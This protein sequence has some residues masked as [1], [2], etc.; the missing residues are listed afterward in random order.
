MRH[1]ILSLI[2][3]FQVVYTVLYSQEIPYNLT[4]AAECITNEDID[5]AKEYLNKELQNNPHSVK[6]LDLLGYIYFRDRNYGKAISLFDKAIEYARKENGYLRIK[7][8]ES[9]ND[10][11]SIRMSSEY[12]LLLEQFKNEKKSDKEVTL[13][14]LNSTEVLE[15]P[16]ILRRT[17]IYTV[18]CFLNEMPVSLVLDTGCTNVSISLIESD[19]MLKNGYISQND[20]LGYENYQDATGNYHKARILLIKKF[21]IGNKVIENVRASVIPN[22]EAPLLLGQN[23]LNRLG[24]V[25]IDP[26]KKILKIYLFHELQQL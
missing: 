1:F 5:T 13:A 8:I 11:D 24:K 15:I 22:Q 14:P 7:H 9:D 3:V 25:E 2:L 18:K 10:L 4:R 23:V 20:F 17:G 21:R 16:L 12:H 26:Q 19:Y 6:G